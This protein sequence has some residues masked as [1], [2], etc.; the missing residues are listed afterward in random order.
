MIRLTQ[1]LTLFTLSLIS[2]SV[3][4]QIE[5]GYVK[6][7]SVSG[8]IG[9]RLLKSGRIIMAQDSAPKASWVADVQ[10]SS[11]RG[12]TVMAVK[13]TSIEQKV[14]LELEAEKIDPDTKITTRN[15][16]VSE[17]SEVW[18]YAIS[19][20]DN[21]EE[22]NKKLRLVL[23]NEPKPP[24]PDDPPNPPPTPVPDDVPNAY[25]VGKVARTNAPSDPVIAK[26]IANWY[27]TDVL[28]LWGNPTLADIATI[29]SDI[30]RKFA[31]KQCK[32]QATCQQWDRWRD[33]V[34]IAIKAEQ[35]RRKTFTREDWKASYEEIA[36][37]LEAVK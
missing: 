37:A 24:K 34:S 20:E 6:E 3:F 14:P 21:D 15:Y 16:V 33:A 23:K 2:S 5:I 18:I 12:V 9:P 26:Q 11:P 27:R 17:E 10:V 4:G 7:L 19:L 28:K 35:T 1:I 31:A 13:P 30:A 8:A 32:D 22:S 29:Q 25:N 36:T